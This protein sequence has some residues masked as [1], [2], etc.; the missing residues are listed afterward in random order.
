M[1]NSSKRTVIC[2]DLYLYC[3]LR[4]EASATN[5]SVSELVNQAVRLFLTE[6]DE[7]ISAFAERRHEPNLPF[8]D[9]LNDLRVQGKI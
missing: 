8:E 7:D 4:I 5:R 3:S 2:F 9:V 6:H 1:K